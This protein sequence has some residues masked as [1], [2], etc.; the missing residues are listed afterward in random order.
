MWITHFRAALGWSP[1]PEE[2]PTVTIETPIRSTREDR[3]LEQLAALA[4]I[5]PSAEF[6]RDVLTLHDDGST[7]VDKAATSIVE[8]PTRPTGA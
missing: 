3:F 6:V 8:A 5:A 2:G 1:G 4:L 7:D